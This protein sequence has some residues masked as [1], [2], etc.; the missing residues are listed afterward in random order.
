LGEAFV[1]GELFAPG[2]FG[3]GHGILTHRSLLT[4]KGTKNTKKADR[5]ILN[6]REQ[7]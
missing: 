4:T 6:R 2:F 3:F 7:R 1:V 5:K